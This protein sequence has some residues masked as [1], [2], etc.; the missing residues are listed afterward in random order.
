[1]FCMSCLFGTAWGPHGADNAAAA[2]A[3]AFGGGADPV[4]LMVDAGINL[5]CVPIKRQVGIPLAD[6]L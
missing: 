4:E 5:G 6:R 3:A 1:M 2:G